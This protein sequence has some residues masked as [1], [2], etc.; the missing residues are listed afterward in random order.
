MGLSHSPRIVTNGLVLC[1]DAANPRSYPGS[2][3]TWY[4]LGKN[5]YHGTLVNSPTFVS[6][7][8]KSHFYF[9]GS[10]ERADF[11]Y[12]QPAYQTTTDFTW[13]LWLYYSSSFNNQVIIGNRNNSA[14][15]SSPLVFTKLTPTN[16]EYY[17]SKLTPNVL[18]NEWHQIIIV[19][20]QTSLFYY[21]NA[22]LQQSITS[23]VT[24]SQ[25]HPFSIGGD[26]TNIEASIVRVNSC[27]IYDIPF[28]AEEVKQHYNATKGRFQ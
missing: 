16:F 3:S 19:K 26:H 12:L 1:L 11:N 7:K 17:P 22:E 18:S 4:D 14:G 24:K 6:D 15:G 27:Q 23:S 20:N 21:I 8:G 13:C 5:K 10:N 28:S 9:D 2:G 25:T